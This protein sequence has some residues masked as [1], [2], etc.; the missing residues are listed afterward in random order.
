[1]TDDPRHCHE[2]GQYTAYFDKVAGTWRC[3]CGWIERRA[4]FCPLGN[5]GALLLCAVLW[6]YPL[7]DGGPYGAGAEQEMRV[8]VCEERAQQFL[9]VVRVTR[10]AVGGEGG[11]GTITETVELVLPWSSTLIPKPDPKGGAK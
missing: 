7:G 9:K 6:A 2:C 11:G 3:P 4:R 1:M 8:V 5:P 10:F